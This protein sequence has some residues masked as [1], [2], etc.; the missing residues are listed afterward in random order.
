[1]QTTQS[2]QP[3]PAHHHLA[4]PR[5]ILVTG[6]S[7]GIGHALTRHLA[8]QGHTVYATARKDA[9]LAALGGI[10][11]V[12]PIRL[13]VRDT[14]QVRAVREAIDVRGTGL[15]GLVN[16]AGIGPLGLLSTWIDD[17]LR[18][19]FDVNVFGVH[20][21][22]NACLDLLLDA[23]GRI[24]NIGSQ[25]G[26][27]TKKYYGPYSMTKFALEAYT[28][29]LDAELGPYGI[30]VSIVQPGGIVT[31]VGRNAMPATLAHFRRARSPF[32]EEAESL[33][34]ALGAPPP[35]P[36]DGPESETNRKPS[37]PDIVVAAVE[38]ALFAPRPKRRYLVGTKWEGDRVINA[39]IAKLLDENDNPYHTY[40][41]DELVALLDQHIANRQT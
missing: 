30:R 12:V 1:M 10:D 11:N 33:L 28:E 16:N 5:P 9:D 8:A 6:A 22:T 19:L 3:S 23:G 29:A 17:E 25:G 35:P 18:D 7:S 32:V 15:Y 37:S 36:S 21:M 31:D 41:R 34:G 26:M 24:V 4:E 13:D 40:T 14:Q 39:L 20:R 27:I 2:D 38:D